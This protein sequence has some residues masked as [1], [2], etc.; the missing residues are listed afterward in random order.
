LDALPGTVNGT[1]A[2]YGLTTDLGSSQRFIRNILSDFISE[3]C[4]PPPTWSS[5]RTKE[6]EICER[7]VPL[8]YH[9]LIPQSTHAKMLK[10][11]IYSETMVGS[12]AWLCRP[13]H[14]ALHHVASN[15]ELAR[16]FTRFI[17]SKAT[18]GSRKRII[19]L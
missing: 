14:S 11:K 18:L 16:V 15:D 17:S 13:C 8:T 9:H 6:C 7:E 3:A 10:K 5:T 2:A 19:V 4:A 12:V 1:L